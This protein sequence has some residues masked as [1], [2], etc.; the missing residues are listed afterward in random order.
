MSSYTSPIVFLKRREV[1]ALTGL[2]RSSIYTK[3]EDGTFPLPVRLDCRSVRWLRSEVE[4]WQRARIEAS[5]RREQK[6][7]RAGAARGAK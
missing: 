2:G 6:I 4:D 5:R 3:M 7:R 1:E